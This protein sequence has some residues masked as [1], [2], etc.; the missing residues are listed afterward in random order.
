MKKSKEE[1]TE[2]IIELL[3]GMSVKDAEWLLHEIREKIQKIT[4]IK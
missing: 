1:I 4:F 2:A 3:K